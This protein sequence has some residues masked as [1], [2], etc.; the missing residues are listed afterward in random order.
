MAKAK[1][2]EGLDCNASII[3]GAKVVLRVRLDEMCALREAAL[4]WDDIEGVHDMR[5][6]SRR[7]RGIIREFEPYF[8]KHELRAMHDEVKRVADALG[9]VRD[10]DVAIAGL[11]KLSEDAPPDVSEGI[12]KIVGE[13]RRRRE[14]ARAVLTE[15][16]SAYALS[17]LRYDCLAAIENAEARRS[18]KNKDKEGLNV[19]ALSFREA[20]QQI[21]SEGWRALKKR[22]AS[23]QRPHKTKPLHKMRITAKR[24]RYAIELYCQCWSEPLRPFA[25][26]LAKLQSALGDLHDCDMWI[27]DLGEQL[28]VLDNK[29]E[30][31]A[32]TLHDALAAKSASLSEEHAKARPT[33]VWLMCHFTTQRAELYRDALKRWHEWESDDFARRLFE[34]LS[35]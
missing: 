21:I 16:I 11:E 15:L 30:D 8:R 29:N 13:R 7:L 2:I 10:E 25:K 26:E 33:V 12:Q 35:T 28:R 34:Q 20:G 3:I 23:L 19:A 17:K 4:N 32:T 24:L 9:G 6:A 18:N 5:V 1:E 27:E 31:A 22:S 14:G